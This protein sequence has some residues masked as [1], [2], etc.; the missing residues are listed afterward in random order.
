MRHL[1]SN[2]GKKE[3]ITRNKFGPANLFLSILR[4][5]HS[6]ISNLTYFGIQ[7]VTTVTRRL[8][9]LGTWNGMYSMSYLSAYCVK[10]LPHMN[11]RPQFA[12][13]WIWC[14][15]RHVSAA[16]R[17]RKR[18]R[19]GDGRKKTVVD[20]RIQIPRTRLVESSWNVMAHGDA[21]EGKWRGNWRMEWVD[22]TLITTLEHD[23]SSIT[24]ADAHTSAAS[25]RLNWRPR[26]FK[27]TRPFRRK[28]KSGFCSCAITFQLAC[29]TQYNVHT[30]EAGCLQHTAA[31]S[32]T[33]M[34]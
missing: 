4:T 22:S 2:S 34:P 33:N 17:R 29:T 23:V 1:T 8:N 12:A 5:R 24:T 11:C 28:T 10:L 31:L 26:R 32:A 15:C 18:R 19:R 7:H 14:I 25:S 13:V 16:V 6:A 27:W 30:A 20:I 3:I 9:L 21:R